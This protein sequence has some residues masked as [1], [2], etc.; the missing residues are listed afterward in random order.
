VAGPS[1]HM[2]YVRA[3]GGVWG[4]YPE[5]RVAGFVAEGRVRAETPISP[6]AEGP[7]TPAA[8]NPEFHLLFAKAAQSPRPEAPAP[9]TAVPRPAA[10][11]RPE[12][13]AT[14]APREATPGTGPLRILVIWAAVDPERLPAF[15]A[16]LG[17]LGAGVTVQPGLWLVQARAAPAAVRNALSRRLAAADQLLVVEATLDQAA[18]FNL[19]RDRD[20]RALW[21]ATTGLTVALP[22]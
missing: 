19:P 6:W 11:E 21:R 4:P 18:W 2:W 15:H 3:A 13:S 10:A 14:P 20:I 16:V 12:P 22:A 9:V 8:A 1:S 5:A 17:G 7:F